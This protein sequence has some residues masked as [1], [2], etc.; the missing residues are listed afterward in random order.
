MR[1]AFAFVNALAKPLAH[2]FG[3]CAIVLA[4]AALSYPS[5]RAAIALA[6]LSYGCAS[7]AHNNFAKTS[8]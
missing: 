8:S 5:T 7:L 3:W 1:L 4:H 2:E 6:S